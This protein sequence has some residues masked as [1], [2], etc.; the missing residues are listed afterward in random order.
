MIVPQ[1]SLDPNLSVYGAARSNTG[2]AEDGGEDA[3]FTLPELPGFVLRRPHSAAEGSSQPPSHY[4]ADI[5]GLD[6]S[7]LH[8]YVHANGDPARAFHCMV[9]AHI[10]VLSPS[11]MSYVMAWLSRGVI[12]YPYFKL[13]DDLIVLNT[14]YA[15]KRAV[16]ALLWLDQEGHSFIPVLDEHGSVD[17]EVAARRLQALRHH[18]R[19]T[20]HK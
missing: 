5:P 7:N 4:L 12:V 20:L 2:S 13:Q 18:R 3:T 11:S 1:A 19:V 16:G 17:V 10:L 14:E 9:N 8:V 6:I 15:L